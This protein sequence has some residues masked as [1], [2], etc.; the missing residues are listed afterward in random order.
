MNNLLSCLDILFRKP[1][2]EKILKGSLNEYCRNSPSQL[3]NKNIFF[4]SALNLK[5]YSDDEKNN[6]FNLMKNKWFKD[7]KLSNQS[8]FNLLKYFSCE[9]LKEKD[10]E[11]ICT[12]QDLLRWSETC[13]YLGEE[14]FTTSFFAYSDL[15][16]QRERKY[17]AWKPVISTDNVRLKELLKQGMAEN[18]CHLKATSQN[19]QISWISLMNNFINKGKSFKELKNK[20]EPE[21]NV[22]IGYKSMPLYNLVKKAAYIRAFLFI[23]IVKQLPECEKGNDY[24]SDKNLKKVLEDDFINIYSYDIQEEIFSLK[25]LFGYC[26]NL[27]GFP[28]VPD[29]ALPH[30]IIPENFNG[31]ILLYGERFLLY[32]VLKEIYRSKDYYKYQD[33]FYAYLVIKSQMRQEIIQLNERVGFANF[34]NYE[35]RK[36]KFIPDNSIYEKFLYYMAINSS[37]KNQNIVSFESRITPKNTH[38]EMAQKIK[39]FDDSIDIKVFDKPDYD[40]FRKFLEKHSFNKNEF[41]KESDKKHFYTIHFIKEREKEFKNNEIK[42]LRDLIYPRHHELRKKIKKQAHALVTLRKSLWP[43]AQ[44]IYGIDAASH[45]IGNRPEIF[46]PAFR[47][48]KNHNLNGRN[49][50]IRFQRIPKLGATYH[51]GEDFLDITDGL[52]AIDETIKFLNLEQGDRLGHALALGVNAVDYYN[53]KF[54]TLLLPK[55]DLLDNIVWMLSRIRKYSINTSHDLVYELEKKYYRLFSEIYSNYLKEYFTVPHHSIFYNAWKLRGEDPLL[56]KSGKYIESFP[57][58][59]WNICQENN[60]YPRQNLREMPEISNL[61]YYYHFDHCVRETGA[62]IEEFEISESYIKTVI[63]V[64]KGMQEFIKTLGIAIETNPTS[65]Y[66]IGTFRTYSKHPIINWFNLGLESETEKIKS[67]RQLF[68]SINTD[69]QGVVH[70]YL[71]NEYALM[72]LALEKEKD[73]NGKNLYNPAMIYDWLDKIRRMGL[74]Q[75]FISRN[76]YEL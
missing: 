11:P 49:D 47:F 32:S 67:C 21:M 19:F 23:K 57:F 72:A 52:R 29:Y 12:Y 46:A 44:R 7:E 69:D 28:E 14:I 20:L 41:L 3:S 18:H 31:N 62:K 50:N 48:L 73:E 9:I 42:K 8:I 74:E 15:K 56:F 24:L 33:L 4:D 2:P 27:S 75:S 13:R 37:M 26:F 61:Y 65:N 17:F 43:E 1:D 68:V 16:G 59:F 70:T 54:K 53:F 45:E 22:E 71:E 51:V 40:R 76:N 63:F 55:H 64:Q 39:F 66:V 25:R 36:D 60:K 30:N 6:L 10:R 5:Q 38:K 35:E 34:Q 58:T